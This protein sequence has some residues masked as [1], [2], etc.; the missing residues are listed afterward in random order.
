MVV[1]C[2]SKGLFP[3]LLVLYFMGLDKCTQHFH[4]KNRIEKDVLFFIRA[5]SPYR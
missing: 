1:I 2:W 4:P 5:T 3:S